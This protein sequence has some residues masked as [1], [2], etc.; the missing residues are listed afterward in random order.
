VPRS[1]N[2]AAM[3]PVTPMASRARRR[4]RIPPCSHRPGPSRVREVTGSVALVGASVRVAVADDFE[5]MRELLELRFSLVDDIDLV[6]QTG[7]GTDAVALVEQL[8]PDVLLLDLS[9][10]GLDGHRVIAEVQRRKPGVAIVVLTGSA[11]LQARQQ[12]LDAGA[13]AC[14]V[15]TPNVI[16]AVI[17]TIRAIGRRQAATEQP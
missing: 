4:K 9:I 8:D 11:T 1:R 6:G 17:E 10:P 15:K 12:A 7:N 5:P 2:P 16:G 3:I 13:T 14:L